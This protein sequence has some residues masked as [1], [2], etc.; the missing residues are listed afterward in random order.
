MIPNLASSDLSKAAVIC[1]IASLDKVPEAEAIVLSCTDMRS[2][3]VVDRIEA[4]LDKPVLTSN[5]AMMFALMHA[6]GLP[7]HGNVPG[8]L[9]DYL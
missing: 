6:L 4:V 8:T 1:E 2:V 5:Q 3:E 9:F 7:R